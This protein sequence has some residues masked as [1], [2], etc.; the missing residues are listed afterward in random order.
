MGLPQ[1]PRTQV[2]D[3]VARA[4]KR[5]IG[6]ADA[7]FAAIPRIVDF[8]DALVT[9]AGKRG[10]GYLDDAAQPFLKTRPLEHE[11]IVIKML[12]GQGLGTTARATARLTCSICLASVV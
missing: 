11:R 6:A 9:R 8:R 12:R 2:A 7:D 1:R 4:H 3:L 5:R 10:A